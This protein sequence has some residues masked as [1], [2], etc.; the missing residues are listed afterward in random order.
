MEDEPVK[1]IVATPTV[2]GRIYDANRL[3]VERLF[4]LCRQ[5]GLDYDIITLT[6][7]L[8]PRARNDLAHLFLTRCWDAT[9]LLFLGPNI[10][11]EAPDILEMVALPH[12]IIGG[13]VPRPVFEWEAAEHS[14]V[15]GI[16]AEAYV[17]P[18]VV[19]LIEGE[20]IQKDGTLKVRGIGLDCLK[21][22]RKALVSVGTECLDYLSDSGPTS[23]ERVKEFFA[24]KN[25]DESFESEGR[26]FIGVCMDA[27]HDIRA[28]V[29]SRG[30][31]AVNFCTIASHIYRGSVETRLGVP[32]A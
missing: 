11:F 32:F 13:V 14:K 31:H 1:L 26:Y 24:A 27:G 28:F 9:D 21:V 22:T 2:E 6:D 4:R 18:L 16:T 30:D 17:H 19:D 7:P 8:L 29:R 3:A 23:G 25:Y 15:T 20:E 5:V 12:D 10:L